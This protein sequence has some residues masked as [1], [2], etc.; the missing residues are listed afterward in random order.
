MEIKQKEKKTAVVLLTRCL[1][2]L[3]FFVNKIKK[4]TQRPVK[5][6]GREGEREGERR[7]KEEKG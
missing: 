6:G 5:E 2:L 7:R 3:S 1:L 4:S